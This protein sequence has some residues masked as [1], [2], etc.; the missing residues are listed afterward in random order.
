MKLSFVE[1][2]AGLGGTRAGLEAAGWKC[3]YA[4]DNDVSVVASHRAAF[5]DCACEDV[6]EL[7]VSAVPAHHVLVAGF[8]CQPFSS[9]GLRT[10]FQHNHGNV[11]H[12]VVRMCA[13]HNPPYIL[14]E[15]VRGLLSNAF[16]HTFA[17]VL[18]ELIA[19]GYSVSWAV[20]DAE[21]FGAPQSRPRVFIIA[22]RNQGPD[23]ATTGAD[24]I[25]YSYVSPIGE[26]RTFRLDAVI[27]ERSPRIGLRR[28]HPQTPFGTVGYASGDECRTWSRA[29]P[30]NRS[31]CSSLGDVVC[32]SFPGK[33][34]VRSV[35]YW[36]H[37]GVTK[38][39]FKAQALAH[40]IGTNIGA[41]P[42]FGVRK[43]LV[44]T[45]AARNALLEHANW[46]REEHE[47]VIFRLVPERAA[48]LFGSH[49]DPIQRALR[50]GAAS[51]TKQYEMLG[52]LVTPEI[53]RRLAVDVSRD[54]A[55]A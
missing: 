49:I 17:T 5:G 12:A 27:A 46:V 42:T 23:D 21:W 30:L 48:L 11:F 13:A 51:V 15:N 43:A 24:G 1:L 36:G 53:M 35:R 39:Y 41:G 44:Q 4:G 50:A 16:G 33:E 3:A 25:L 32:P 34:S 20:L 9:S 47:H 52:N 29:V 31:R 37:S 38:P 28:P 22:K 19:I 2:C 55:G 14:L 26:S 18:R 40:C 7:P 10:G 6:R 54:M 45:T 8:P